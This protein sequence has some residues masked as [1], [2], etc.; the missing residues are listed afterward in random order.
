MCC[1]VNS[2]PRQSVQLGNEIRNEFD[3]NNFVDGGELTQEY[4]FH[5]P[6]R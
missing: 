5:H 6:C 2:T 1:F 3:M 4:P